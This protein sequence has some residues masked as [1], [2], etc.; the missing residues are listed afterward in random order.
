MLVKRTLSAVPEFWKPYVDQMDNALTGDARATELT[1]IV[2]TT[3]AKKLFSIYEASNHTQGFV[4]AQINPNNASNTE[5]MIEE[6]KYVHTWAPNMAVK[7][8]ATGSGIAAMEECAALGITTVGTV[9]YTVPQAIA[10]AQ[11]QWRGKQRAIQN[12]VM[13]GQAFSVIMLGRLESF[14]RDV[15]HDNHAFVTEEDI[16]YAGMAVSK[17][18]YQLIREAGYDAQLMPAGMGCIYHAAALS[19]GDMTMT[20]SPNIQDALAGVTEL[21]PRIDELVPTDAIARLMTMPEFVRAY[22][23][24]GMRPDQFVAFGSVQ[25]TLSQFVEVGWTPLTT[26]AY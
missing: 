21:A 16:S 22:E 5:K 7:M 26:F 17:R 20:I 25:R 15:A 18:A 13:P 12:G 8:P 6:A 9:N 4:C 19:G 14:L 11:A 23:P 3:I 24:D 10:V 2:T 1:R